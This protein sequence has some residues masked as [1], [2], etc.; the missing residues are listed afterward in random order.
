MKFKL[1]AERKQFKQDLLYGRN[2]GGNCKCF[3]C[4]YHFIEI[5]V[6]GS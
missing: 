1:E 2:N 6:Y 4:D 3:V 5:I